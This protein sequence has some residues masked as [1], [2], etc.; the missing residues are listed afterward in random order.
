MMANILTKIYY[1]GA[2]ANTI[3]T[4]YDPL[5]P[6]VTKS[7][8]EDNVASASSTIGTVSPMSTNYYLW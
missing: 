7:I 4:D 3:V 8:L 2:L 5:E 6:G 1:K